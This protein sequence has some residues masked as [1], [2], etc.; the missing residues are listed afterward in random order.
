[1]SSWTALCLTD[2]YYDDDQNGDN[3]Y[4]L[5]YYSM[6][7]TI[8]WEDDA[9]SIGTLM[10]DETSMKDAREYFSAVCA[11]HANRISEEW[12]Y[13]CLRLSD[14]IHKYVRLSLIIL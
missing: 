3:P 4:M 8:E 10:A 1:M 13:V 6:E 7:P 11:V 12:D 5:P 14:E 2:S 9:I